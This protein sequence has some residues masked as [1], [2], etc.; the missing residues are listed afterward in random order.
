MEVRGRDYS[1]NHLAILKSLDFLIIEF[2]WLF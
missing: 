1:K 2:I